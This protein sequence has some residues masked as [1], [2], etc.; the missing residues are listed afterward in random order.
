LRNVI[1]EKIGSDVYS[2][3]DKAGEL[4]KAMAIKTGL[5]AGT[6]VGA[7][8]TDAHLAVPAVGLRSPVIW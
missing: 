8:N 7:G 2:V 6:A 4:T 5:T 1:D 3:G